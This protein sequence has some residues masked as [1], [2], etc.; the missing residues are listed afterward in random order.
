MPAELVPGE[1]III[2]YS[3]E[4]FEDG[5]LMGIFTDS[6]NLTLI[7]RGQA[8]FNGTTVNTVE[9]MYDNDVSASE[10]YAEGLGFFSADL[11]KLQSSEI[12]SQEEWPSSRNSGSSGGAVNLFWLLLGSL[13]VMARRRLAS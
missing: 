12:S 5:N 2:A 11:V 1:P 10:T 3:Y 7:G 4:R 6:Y 9:L 8:D 13:G